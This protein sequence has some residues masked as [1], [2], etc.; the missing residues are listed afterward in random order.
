[1]ESRDEAG[2]DLSPQ[3]LP[4]SQSHIATSAQG[5]VLWLKMW[6]MIGSH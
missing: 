5:S 1:M 2:K 4:R 3:L 6:L